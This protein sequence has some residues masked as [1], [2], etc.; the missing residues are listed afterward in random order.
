MKLQ[1]K[2][3]D[4]KKLNWNLKLTFQNVYTKILELFSSWRD[5]KCNERTTRI[6]I[7]EPIKVGFLR[8]CQLNIQRK[9]G[10][11]SVSKIPDLGK[12]NWVWKP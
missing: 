9:L 12:L 1:L 11:E 6:K 8:T 4:E 7:C 10:S 3:E 5:E 2:T